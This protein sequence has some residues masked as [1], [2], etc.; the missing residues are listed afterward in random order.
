MYIFHPGMDRMEAIIRQH[1]Y[2]P[3]IRKATRKKANN[4]DTCQRTKW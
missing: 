1:F 4:C 2:W 3:G